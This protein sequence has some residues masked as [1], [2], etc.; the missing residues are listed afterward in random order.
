[1]EQSKS[2]EQVYKEA[3][4]ALK[5]YLSTDML[6]ILDNDDPVEK[7]E[8]MT[9]SNIKALMNKTR[10]MPSLDTQKGIFS[11]RV[12][13]SHRFDYASHFSLI[14][15]TTLDKHA[16]LPQEKQSVEQLLTDLKDALEN[17]CHQYNK[18]LPIHPGSN[19]NAIIIKIQDQS[20]LNIIN[21]VAINASLRNDRQTDLSTHKVTGTNPIVVQPQAGALLPFLTTAEN[22]NPSGSIDNK[23]ND[24]PSD[25]NDPTRD[26]PQ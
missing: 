23:N 19:F 17:M 12:R 7:K 9:L 22:Q 2:N 20:K 11:N 21:Q 3:I 26:G 25:S 24:D 14:I 4:F 15:I 10:D 5:N 18:L 8:Q 13:P 6:K 16:N 1:M